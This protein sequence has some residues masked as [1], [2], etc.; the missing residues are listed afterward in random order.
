[1]TVIGMIPFWKS[2]IKSFTNIP[3][4]SGKEKTKIE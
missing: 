2:G 3:K 1:M 4:E